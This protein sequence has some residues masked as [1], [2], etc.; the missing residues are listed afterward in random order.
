MEN[1]KYKYSDDPRRMQEG[2]PPL[3]SDVP[4]TS[5][6]PPALPVVAPG[7]PV[8]PAPVSRYVIPG[9]PGGN[10]PVIVEPPVIYGQRPDISEN[11]APVYPAPTSDNVIPGQPG[12]TLP[13]VVQ[14]KVIHIQAPVIPE[15]EAPDHLGTAILVTICCCLPFGIVAIVKATKCRSARMR[16]DR[17][18]ARLYSLQAKKYAKLGLSIGIVL[19]VIALVKEIIGLF[20]GRL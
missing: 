1:N 3:Y 16:G 19:F 7:V 10:P 8:N 20:A 9:Q 11:E 17:E 2:V 18:N 4:S 15:Y 14:P 5:T 6:Y 12:G 13:V